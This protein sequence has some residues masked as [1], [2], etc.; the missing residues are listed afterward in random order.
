MEGD[1]GAMEIDA[2]AC[3]SRSPNACAVDSCQRR[4]ALEVIDE[5]LGRPGAVSGG[6]ADLLLDLR[7]Q[8]G[9]RG[10][11]EG[12]LKL[13]CDLRLLMERRHYLAFFRIRRWLENH[14]VAQVRI[15]P[16]AVAQAVPVR[17]NHY[18]VQ[19]IRRGTL[20]EAL[21]RGAVLLAP[22]LEFAFREVAPGVAGTVNRAVAVAGVAG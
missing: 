22:R 16:A 8:L 9:R 15:C 11:A 14:L 19:A 5:L 21:N 4:C 2:A 20:C 18:C 1:L 6:E 7:W 3:A 13:F 12:A 10:D 17:L